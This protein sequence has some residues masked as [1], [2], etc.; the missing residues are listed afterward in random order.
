MKAMRTTRVLHIFGSLNRGGIETWLMNIL[1]L[2]LKN[3]QF[4]F[5][6][7]TLGG[8]YEEEAKSY[9]CQMYQAPPI[10]QLSKYLKELGVLIEVNKYDVVHVHGEEFMGDVVKVA[11][12]FDVPVRIAHCHGTQLA[13]GKKGFLMG[14]RRLRHRSIDRML[15]RKHA[16]HVLACSVDAGRFLM[17]D[18][19][20]SDPRCETLYCGVPLGLFGKTGSSSEKMEL[21]KTYGIPEDAIVIGHA[22]SMGPTPVKNHSFIIDVFSELYQSDSRLYL[23]LAGD[24]PDRDIIKAKI[25]NLGLEK[26]VIMPGVC[27]DVPAL[28]IHVFDVHLL[29]SLWEGLPIAGLE[30]VAS[31]LFTVCS[32]SITRDYTDAF[33][34]RIKA[35]SLDEGLTVWAEEVEAGVKKR[36]RTEQGAVLIENSQFS[37]QSS[38]SA[39]VKLYLEGGG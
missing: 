12:K 35:L 27:H 30:A 14:L 3:I 5:Y 22:G 28:M 6:L 38:S 18:S 31:G 20:V 19:W 21:R 15:I 11:R 1:R 29:P 7:N 26:R 4:D 32:D 33:R 17:G 25:N 39:L 9:D 34:Q 10:R 24:G 2:G 13:R 36:M 23:F 37:I 8:D 16:T